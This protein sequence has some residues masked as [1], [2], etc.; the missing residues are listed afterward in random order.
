MTKKQKE[1]TTIAV[2]SIK[3]SISGK[4]IEVTLGR[5]FQGEGTGNIHPVSAACPGAYLP[6]EGYLRG[7]FE[8]LLKEGDQ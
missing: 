8:R 2:T 3:L 5:A 7:Y 1:T 6:M 4:E